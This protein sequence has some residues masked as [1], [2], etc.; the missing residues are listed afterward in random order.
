MERNQTRSSPSSESSNTFLPEFK[1]VSSGL[2]FIFDTF[3]RL[4]VYP[5]NASSGNSSSALQQLQMT[6]NACFET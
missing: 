5:W 1:N 6:T 4:L 2:N 3:T